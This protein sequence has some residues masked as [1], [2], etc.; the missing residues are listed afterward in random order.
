MDH[1]GSPNKSKIKEGDKKVFSEK[2]SLINECAVEDISL[3]VFYKPH[4]IAALLCSIVVV[5]VASFIR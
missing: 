2:F 4:T 3:D 1:R 5:I